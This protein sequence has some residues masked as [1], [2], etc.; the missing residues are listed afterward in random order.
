MKGM[1]GMKNK[2]QGRGVSVILGWDQ[3]LPMYSRLP[4]LPPSA[5]CQK[6]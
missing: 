4:A 5:G 3:T 6:L 1:K 2:K